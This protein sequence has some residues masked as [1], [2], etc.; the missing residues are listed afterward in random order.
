LTTDKL[1]A[2]E[3]SSK[4][5]GYDYLDF[6]FG[7]GLVGERTGIT[8]D[9][10]HIYFLLQEKLHIADNARSVEYTVTWLQELPLASIDHFD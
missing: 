5:K 2:I 10:A 8:I 9:V 4:Q 7:D 6:F 3:K 1:E